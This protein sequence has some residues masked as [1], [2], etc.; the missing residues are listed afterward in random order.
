[1]QGSVGKTTDADRPWFLLTP[2]KL[3]LDRGMW[4]ER[5]RARRGSAS[6]VCGPRPGRSAT[7][8]GTG[9]WVQA[10]GKRSTVCGRLVS[11]PGSE[12][13]GTRPREEANAAAARWDHRVGGVCVRAAAWR[14]GRGFDC[15]RDAG[16]RRRLAAASSTGFCEPG[17]LG[18]YWVG[19]R[20]IQH[21]GNTR[22]P[23]GPS[24]W[25]R[26]GRRKG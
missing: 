8:A 24:A 12:N 5:L 11:G 23:P 2:A 1:M 17:H 20:V 21:R 22:S 7:R 13:G 6:L 18:L 9:Q 10:W 19:I 25:V 4:N 26:C 3:D 14:V 16:H 15:V